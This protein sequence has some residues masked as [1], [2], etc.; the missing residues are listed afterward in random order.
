MTPTPMPTPVTVQDPRRVATI[1][2][3][4]LLTGLVAFLVAVTF[5]R[6]VVVVPF[7]PGMARILTGFA[8][9]ATVVEVALSRLVPRFLP[10]RGMVTPDQRAL[11]LNIVAAAL[12]VGAGLL[13][14]VVWLLTGTPWIFPALAVALLGLLACFPSDGRWESLGGGVRR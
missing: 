5:A 14:V 7:D 9:A 3:G 2:W 4:A 10:K 6:S 1:V 12:C 11:T 13:G 8:T